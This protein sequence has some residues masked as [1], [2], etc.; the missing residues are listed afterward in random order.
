MRHRFHSLC[1]YFAMFPEAFA[2]RWIDRLTRPGHVVLDPF[3]GR[4]TAPF[5]ALLMGRSAIGFDVNPVAYCLT[6]AKT[7]APSLEDA[8]ARVEELR[9]EHEIAGVV[10]RPEARSEFFDHAF[11]PDTL[12]QLLFIR[13]RLNWKGS[14]IDCMIAAIAL[15]ALHGE[16]TKSPSYFSN[17]MPRT[18]STKPAY[19]VRFWQARGL[20]A[21]ERDVF[22]MLRRLLEYRYASEAPSGRAIVFNLD[23][24]EIPRV[25]SVGHGP[26]RCVITSPPYIDVTN[27]EEDQWL[28]LWLLGGPPRPTKSRMSRDDRHESR[29]AYW[30]LV[31]DMWR[32]LG[33]IV[34]ERGHIVIRIGARDMSPEQL[35][36][37]L[38]GTSV[39]SGRR[40]RLADFEVSEIRGRQTDAFRPGSAGCLREIDCHFVMS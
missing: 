23:M 24:R 36:A 21:P 3:C 39:A 6:R 7:N 9:R 34:D 13:D 35:R 28:R 20:V 40:V 12:Q 38:V 15:G 29:D 17:Q 22:A 11:H 37:G 31:A 26:V 32:S 14:D 27:F 10:T 33:Q 18:I 4:G 2:E 25:L 16:S 5:Q 1:P 8:L 30:R 19:S